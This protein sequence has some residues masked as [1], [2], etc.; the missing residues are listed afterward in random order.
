[1]VQLLTYGAIQQEVT[2]GSLD[3]VEQ[4]EDRGGAAGEGLP[5][6]RGR[7]DALT[8]QQAELLDKILENMDDPDL[9][10]R[11]KALAEEKQDILDQIAMFQED[12][13]QQVLQTSRQRDARRVAGPAASAADGL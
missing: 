2:E 8:A 9:N 3:L 12:E 7:L 4:A 6:L 10:A 1:M 13:L 11:L 5:V